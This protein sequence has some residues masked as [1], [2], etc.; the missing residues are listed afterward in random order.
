ML[1]VGAILGIGLLLG[2]GL[3]GSI[4]NLAWARL[5][6][7]WLAPVALALQ[8]APIPR[9][10]GEIGAQLPMGT[11][12]FS[13]GLLLVVAVANWRVRG[14]GMVFL[15]V[16][17]NLA[18]IAANRG[19]PVSEDA[20]RAVGAREDVAVLRAAEPGA[21]HR[22]ASDDD[23]LVFLADV[24]AV[25]DPFRTV[26]SVG[27]VFLYAGAAVFLAAAMVGRPRRG[28]RDDEPPPDQTASWS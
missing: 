21:K 2:W 18:V 7:W 15:G 4:R 26:V 6:L 13:Y 14:F 27:D 9:L 19:M 3:H 16:A 1:L 5:R 24:I 11:L 23:E 10:S 25:R 22:L 20:L 8:V 17:M 12:L 28:D